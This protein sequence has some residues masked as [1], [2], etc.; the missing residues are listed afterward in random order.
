METTVYVDASDW[1]S[2]IVAERRVEVEA[3]HLEVRCEIEAGYVVERAPTFESAFRTLVALVLETVPD[4]CEIFVEA[5]RET[6]SV[7]RLG[8]GIWTIRWQLI[9]ERGADGPSA[10]GAANVIALRPETLSSRTASAVA[11]HGVRS[12]RDFESAGWVLRLDR[13]AGEGEMIARL[14][15]P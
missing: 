14:W 4:E 12:Q 10:A 8:A 2:E 11:R 6:A 15:R 3:R 13:A 9:D 5:G 1:L 7:S